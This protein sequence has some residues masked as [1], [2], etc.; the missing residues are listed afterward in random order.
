M[1]RA[2]FTESRYYQNHTWPI[3]F[4][5]AMAGVVC[6]FLGRRLNGGEPRLLVDPQTG[7]E[8]VLRPARHKLFFIKI[9]YWAPIFITLAAYDF[10]ERLLKAAG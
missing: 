4:A 5:V 8:I 9:E 2:V 3:P 6:Y 7:E 10:V 1:T